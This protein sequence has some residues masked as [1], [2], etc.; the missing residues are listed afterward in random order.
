M[1]IYEALTLSKIDAQGAL[2]WEKE[3]RSIYGAFIHGIVQKPNGNLWLLGTES[4]QNQAIW[5]VETNAEGDS[6]GEIHLGEMNDLGVEILTSMDGFHYVIAEGNGQWVGKRYAKVWK[7][8]NQGQVLWESAYYYQ[9]DSADY[10]N[11][12]PTRARATND[13]GLVMYCRSNGAH[14]NPDSAS[15]NAIYVLKI[16]SDGETQWDLT[17]DHTDIQADGDI[18]PLSSGGYLVTIRRDNDSGPYPIAYTYYARLSDDGT[19]VINVSREPELVSLSVEIHPN[20]FDAEL[21]GSIQLER[22]EELTIAVYDL[23]GRE[24]SSQD[25]QGQVGQNSFVIA[26]DHLPPA[27]Y[28]LRVSGP[29]GQ[30]SQV[31]VKR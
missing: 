16:G 24:V 26:T 12:L 2:L 31:V 23:Q 1:G 25:I 6:L 15:F 19:P 30:W 28:L 14:P 21:H 20:P 17:I 13:G 29:D 8:T 4:P 7:L 22:P 9:G 18:I 10:R 11:V 27:S 3:Y 5:L